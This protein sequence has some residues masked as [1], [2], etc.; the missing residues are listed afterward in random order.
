MSE[1]TRIQMTQRMH[2]LYERQKLLRENADQVIGSNDPKPKQPSKQ[3]QKTKRW[4][5]Y[6]ESS[7]AAALRRIFEDGAEPWW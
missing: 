4:S 3:D 5:Y 1:I 2:A 6:I 7:T